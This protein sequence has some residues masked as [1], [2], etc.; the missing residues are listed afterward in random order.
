MRSIP[1]Y[2]VFA[3]IF[4]SVDWVIVYR[5]NDGTAIFLTKM[6][7]TFKFSQRQEMFVKLFAAGT[8]NALEGLEPKDAAN[9]LEGSMDFLV[10]D[11]NFSLAKLVSER[12]TDFETNIRNQRG[13]IVAG[14]S[15]EFI[16]IIIDFCLFR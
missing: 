7:V 10:G 5:N 4:L 12:N 14:G 16:G 15:G 1:I 13:V 6:K 9:F 2:L 11:T 3:R 8:S